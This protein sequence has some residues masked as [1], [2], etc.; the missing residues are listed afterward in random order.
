MD[1]KVDQF[2]LVLNGYTYWID[3]TNVGQ[4]RPGQAWRII[5]P[6]DPG[7]GF[8]S[9]CDSTSFAYSRLTYLYAE[10][11]TLT[12]HWYFKDD[13]TAANTPDTFDGLF[14]PILEK[15]FQ[16]YIASKSPKK[17][18]EQNILPWKQ[19]NV[20][21]SHLLEES[22]KNS[23][24]TRIAIENGRY[25]VDIGLMKQKNRVS[26]NYRDVRRRPVPLEF[27]LNP[28][29]PPDCLDVDFSMPIPDFFV[30]RE[31]AP[32][33]EI[34]LNSQDFDYQLISDHISKELTYWSKL[35]IVR[36]ENPELWTHYCAKRKSMLSKLKS[37][38]K[39]KEVLLFHGTSEQSA[40][41]ISNINFD[42]RLAGTNIGHNFGSGVYFTHKLSTAMSYSSRSS[43]ENVIMVGLV[44]LGE[45]T[46][47]SS[48]MRRP[49]NKPEQPDLYDSCVNNVNS[50]SYFVIFD[51]NQ[52]YP[53]YRINL[54]TR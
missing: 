10:G 46:T 6:F 27:S 11:S 35:S 47:G 43:S 37:L 17:I 40:R 5:D 45:F 48:N 29:E 21:A 25:E 12:W 23:G 49:P 19:F 8:A 52:M 32:V 30:T 18:L 41:Q 53:M 15:L 22:F 33:S 26:G 13:E 24:S 38:D 34:P 31:G 3:F 7:R 14:R 9:G 16:S 51:R 4:S 39:L 28:Q 54:S 36:I 42:I 20:F 1:P 44:L 50:P 2:K